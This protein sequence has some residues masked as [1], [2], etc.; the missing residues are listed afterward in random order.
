MGQI[1]L[2]ELY[3]KMDWNKA[4]LANIQEKITDSTSN[5]SRQV[6]NNASNSRLSNDL[7]S[8]IREKVKNG[9]SK[10]EV[11][12]KFSV[13]YDFVRGNTNDIATKNNKFS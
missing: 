1:S 6:K 12:I 9:K 8:K 13:S 4:E 2:A 11:A 3:P 5:K 7:I 10:I